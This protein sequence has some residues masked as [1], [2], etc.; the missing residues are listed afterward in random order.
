MGI[1]LGSI[2]DEWKT[3]EEGGHSDEIVPLAETLQ[4]LKQRH[5]ATVR[6]SVIYASL[7][8]LYMV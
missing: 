6:L 1:L 3:Q 8:T 5:A 4:K 2:P 7:R